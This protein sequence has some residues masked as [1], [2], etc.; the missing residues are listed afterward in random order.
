MSMLSAQIDELRKAAEYYDDSEVA[1]IMRYAA[2]TIWQLRDDLQR[3]NA[4]N[5][6]LREMAEKAW[7]AAEMLCQAWD[8]PCHADGVS[9]K[10][11][12]PLDERDEL[13]V[14]GLIQRDLRELGVEVD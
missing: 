11:P 7:K 13:C 2:Y 4:D 14:Y 6:R 10:P 8:G 12:C 9:I 1:S 3:A 5:A